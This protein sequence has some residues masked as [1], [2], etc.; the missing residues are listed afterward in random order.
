LI[1]LA[2][3]QNVMIGDTQD[4][5]SNPAA[6][7]LKPFVDIAGGLKRDE[8]EGYMRVIIQANMNIAAF[9]GINEQLTGQSAN[10]EGL[11]GMQ[12]LLINS[13]INALYYVNEAIAHQHQKKFNIWGSVIKLAVENGGKT[14]KAIINTI[15]TK[16]TAIID[17]L[18]QLALHELGIKISISQRE[19]ERAK[20]NE[21]VN[22]LKQANIITIADEYMLD[23]LENPKDKIAFLAVKEKLYRKKLEATEQQRFA[24]QQELIAQQGEQVMA[25]KQQEGEI[26]ANLKYVEGDVQAKILQLSSQLGLNAAQFDALIKKALQQDRGQLAIEKSLKT[27]AA[28]HNLSNQE[29]I[30]AV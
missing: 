2:F 6:A 25:T 14:K 27:M 28:K 19:E 13:S 30:N 29:A 15:G 18:E 16:K 9:T 21:R 22:R 1:N 7:Q 5:D 26:K 11:I 20:F 10:P 12:K 3:E 8:V 23:A 17:G 24:Q 4:F